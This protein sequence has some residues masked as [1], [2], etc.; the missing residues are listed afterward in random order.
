MPY[1]TANIKRDTLAHYDRMMA[2]TKS[3]A[4]KEPALNLN[5]M[6]FRDL[7]K[8]GIGENWYGRYCLYCKNFYD[9]NEGHLKCIACPL[10]TYS[11]IGGRRECCAGL[12]SLIPIART[13]QELF[14]ALSRV[15]D[16]IERNG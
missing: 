15:R 13:Y 1:N 10:V 7:M 14:V 11:C 5:P 16:Y 2:W 4:E 6:E 8:K 12:W 3:Q 9:Y